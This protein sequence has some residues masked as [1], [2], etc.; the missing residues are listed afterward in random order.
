MKKKKPKNLDANFYFISTLLLS[1]FYYYFISTLFSRI[2]S[3]HLHIRAKHVI[4][5]SNNIDGFKKYFL[6]WKK[7]TELTFEM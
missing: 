3:Y 6:L 1:T 7:L 4:S 2:S 5:L